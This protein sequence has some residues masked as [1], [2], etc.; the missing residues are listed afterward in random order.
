MAILAECP[1]CRTKQATK[2]K[3]CKC[4]ADLDKLKKSKKVRY[5][6]DF[7]IPGRSVRRELV[8]NSIEE[9]RDANGKR[10][11][12]K[13]EH[14]I[15]DMLPESKMSF[16]Q[17]SEWYLELSSV[18]KLSSYKRIQSAFK[19]FNAKF[20]G[21]VVNTI[22]L[23]DLEEYQEGRLDGGLAPGTIDVEMAIIKG[24]VNKAFYNRK[25]DGRIFRD[26][27]QLKNKIKRG[28]NARSRT[29]T[30]EEY[31]KLLS[32]APDYLRNFL[33]VAYNTGMRPGEL[34]QL[35]WQYINL[36]AGL[37]VFPKE[38]TKEKAEKRIPI[39]HHVMTVLNDLKPV[40]KPVTADYHDFVLTHN[41][42]PIRGV[43]GLKYILKM[44]CKSA[45]LPYGRKDG[46]IMHD[47]RRSAKTNM[48]SA[49]ID[50]V[51]RNKILGH[52]IKG[53]D[54]HYLVVSDGA[55][56]QAMDTY[57]DWLDNQILN[58]DQTLDQKKNNVI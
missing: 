16:Q 23:A 11:V 57:T 48:L 26:F 15:F 24:M 37:I 9:A 22:T 56:K 49:G 51:Y 43:G 4:G 58:L 54:V 42:R 3:V 53:I 18:K 8:G 36:N 30:I 14:R 39:N 41:G 10:R 1:L 29:V 20:G 55:L 5:W 13:K 6:I 7:K 28:G 32:A 2:N 47:F 27:K 34:R 38:I 52:S 33:I 25:I 17:L 35:R 40:L 44:T 45:G 46:I 12:Q 31:L 21:Q 50:A 19:A